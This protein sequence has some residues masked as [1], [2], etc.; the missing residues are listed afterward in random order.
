VAVITDQSL[1]NRE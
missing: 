1:F